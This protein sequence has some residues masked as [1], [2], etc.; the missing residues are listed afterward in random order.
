MSA[1]ERESV[2]LAN[3]VVPVALHPVNVMRDEANGLAR[4]IRVDRLDG[5]LRAIE[6]RF[7]RGDRGDGVIL[8]V[9][10]KERVC[11]E[12]VDGGP[13]PVPVVCQLSVCPIARDGKG[14]PLGDVLPG[15][16]LWQCVRAGTKK[17][18][19]PYL[20]VLCISAPLCHCGNGTHCFDANDT[21]ESEVRL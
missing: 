14:F 1:V 16:F 4:A 10:A 9:E 17:Y 21:L 19:Y 15:N 20:I 6:E 7:S 8:E 2:L 11:E 3:C 13:G 5:F 12:I 18:L